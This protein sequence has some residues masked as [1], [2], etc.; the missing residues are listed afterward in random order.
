[1]NDISGAAE[2]HDHRYGASAERF[3]NYACTIVAKRWKHEHISRSEVLEDFRMT[4][5]PAEENSLLD[6]KGS[7]KLL[8]AVPLRSVTDHRKA[9]QIAAQKGSRRAQSKITSLPG[10]QA[11]DENQLKFGAGFRTARV[12]ETQAA[13]NAR[14][15]DKKQFVAILGKLGIRLGRRGYDRCRVTIGRASER[16]ISIQIPQLGHPFLLVVELA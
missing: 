6:P 4:E 11:A 3:E 15:R 5:P 13:S 16:Q 10:N 7:H 2:V 12:T 1:M 8:K 9:G 14:L